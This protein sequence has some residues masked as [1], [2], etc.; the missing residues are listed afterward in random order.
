[1]HALSFFNLYRHN[2]VR[3]AVAT[4]AVRVAD[5]AFN[6]QA[7]VTLMRR[8]DESHAL[9]ALFPELGLTGYSCEDLFHQQALEH[10]CIDALRELL[11]A[12]REIATI[13]VVGLPVAVEGAL[14]NCA[15]V[16]HRGQ[17]LGVV[18]KSYLPNYREFYERRQFA[19]AAVAQR[20]AIDL[21]GQRDVPFGTR[22]LFRPRGQPLAMFHVE[23]CE[24]LWV[25]IPP[26]SHAALAGATL[27][28]NLSASNATIGKA[29][30]RRDLVTGQS[31]RC[32]AAY[33]YA[34][35]GFGESTTDLA[36]DG[37]ALVAENG[38]L[39]GE[40]R[41]FSMEPQLLTADVD[42]DRLLQDR[43]QQTS[44]ADAAHAHRDAVRGHRVIDIDF[45][46]P[47][48]EV[49][50]PTR[51]PDRFPFVPSDAAR[52]NERCEEVMAIQT[53]GLAQRM[54]G[55]GIERL[56]IGVSGG[57][58]SAHALLVC[59]SAVDRL[60]LPRSSIHACTLPGFA[61]SERTLDQARR[62]TAAVGATAHE[63]D[64]RPACRQLLRAIGHGH[65]DERPLYDRVFENV[66]AGERSNHLFRLAGL[67]GAMVVGTSDLSELAL[68]W[69]TY[70]IGD[71]M[72]HY[73][74]SAS[75]PKTLIQYLVRWSAE[76]AHTDAALSR[77]LLDVLATQI[78]PELV[79]GR[80]GPAS[81]EATVG[82]YEL[83]DFTLYYTLRFGYRPAKVA[84]LA[85]LAWREHGHDIASIKHWLRVFV[86]RFFQGSQYKRSCIANGPKVGSGGA[87][88]PRGD[89]RAPSDATARVWLDDVEEIPD[90][91]PGALAQAGAASGLAG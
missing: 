29:D 48:G 61:T 67:H 32:I 25:P 7:T 40:S 42:L 37:H 28:L 57:L 91:G 81:S 16:L 24:D 33:A 35:A 79:P 19:P 10:A 18:P 27:L 8:A 43:A 77:V 51:V 13:A 84:F 85:W 89:W 54:R 73:H 49:L 52:R 17:L 5:P 14:F 3:L 36:W 20:E 56:V 30:Y 76:S 59:A 83:Q 80:E 2:F 64:I 78:S 41:R 11:L 15:A 65:S 69:C 53:Q 21:C 6:A 31:A 58:D 75:V 82:P 50:L 26:S 44:F 62:L 60:G 12:S 70:G 4:P 71:H 86:Q 1:M 46:L 72:A 90:V 23:L 87:L 68:G 66:Q 88:S 9:L 22:L 39:L 38:T 45:A 47:T 55:A 34:A 74:V 63:I